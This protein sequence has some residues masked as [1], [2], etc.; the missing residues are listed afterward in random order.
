MEDKG[1]IV[2]NAITLVMSVVILSVFAALVVGN[3]LDSSSVS[4]TTY[5]GTI[6]NETL[7]EVSNVTNSTF[8]IISTDSTATCTLSNAFNATGGEVIE[9][10]GNYTFYTNCRIIFQDDSPYLGEDVNVT[11]SYSYTTGAN[12][13]VNVTEIKDA[14][15]DFITG[16]LAF[17]AIIGTILG[18][19]WLVRYVRRLFDKEE[20]LTNLT[21]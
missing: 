10:E 15:G 4:G 13:I 8:S 9:G 5:S 2:M 20:G 3:I 14:F 1:K 21:A 7:S 17:L 16:L 6:D 18:V 19:L 11:Y 12:Q